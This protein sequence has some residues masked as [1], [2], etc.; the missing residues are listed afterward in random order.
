MEVKEINKGKPV[1]QILVVDDEPAVCDAIKMMLE[2][3]GHEV[4]TVDGGEAAL[5]MLEHNTF[6]LITTD[7]SMAGMKGN[8]LAATVKKCR[9]D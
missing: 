6:D 9:P 1:W 2:H 7:Y 8:Q 5:V 4:Q 3:D